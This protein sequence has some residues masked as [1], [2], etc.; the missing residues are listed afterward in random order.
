MS[1]IKD[2]GEFLVTIFAILTTDSLNDS[3]AFAFW[4]IRCFGLIGLLLCLNEALILRYLIKIIY[5]R[6]II[7]N[8]ALL[9]T[10]IKL[11]NVLVSLTLVV[12]QS[13]S[14][15]F[16]RNLKHFASQK[17]NE[18]TDSDGGWN[19]RFPLWLYISHLSFAF[20]IFLHAFIDKL[21][22][23]NSTQVIHINLYPVNNIINNQ[24][25]NQDL[26]NFSSYLICVL[27][28]ATLYIPL[29]LV[30]NLDELKLA[31][32]ANY[33]QV[34]VSDFFTIF[35]LIRTMIHALGLGF[36]TPLLLMLS[37]SEL[38]PF[39][40]SKLSS[41]CTNIEIYQVNG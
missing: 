20:V 37:S 8:D 34:S 27:A 28:M 3:V 19:L 36:F 5:K 25:Y 10:W 32:L 7:M 29:A 38:R 24:P 2:L 12:L 4:F 11:S 1:M 21:Q 15:G 17:I 41:S 26:M 18:K 33:F 23:R 31:A 22:N 16:Q 40:F 39:L 9:G 6:I 14:L 30:V 35:D 13:Q